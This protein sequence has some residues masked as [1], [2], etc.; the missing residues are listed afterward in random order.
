MRLRLVYP[1][2]PR[3]ILFRRIQVLF[4]HNGKSGRFGF[5]AEALRELGWTGAWFRRIKLPND[6]FDRPEDKLFLVTNSALAAGRA[7]ALVADRLKATG[8]PS[9]LDRRAFRLGESAVPFGRS[10]RTRRRSSSLNTII[11]RRKRTLAS[12]RNSAS[13]ASRATC[14]SPANNAV[15]TLSLSGADRVVTPTRF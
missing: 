13:Q 15:L 6:R 10:S 3:G 4:V 1:L 7:V 14:A 11:M 8:L 2:F 5:I 12:I 9:G